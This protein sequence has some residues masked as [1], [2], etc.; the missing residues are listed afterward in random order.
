MG[1]LLVTLGGAEAPLGV[2]VVAVLTA[3][4][5]AKGLV[6]MVTPAVVGLTLTVAG[7]SHVAVMKAQAVVR[8]TP[9][10]ADMKRKIMQAV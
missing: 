5:R 8:P 7:R 4:A 3:V 10:V 9:A 1:I 6:L 2:A